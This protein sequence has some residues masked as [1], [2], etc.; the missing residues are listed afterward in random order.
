[1]QLLASNIAESDVNAQAELLRSRD[2]L[3]QALDRMGTLAM[4]AFARDQAIDDLER[5]L[6]VGPIPGSNLLQVSYTGSSPEKAKDVLQAITSSFVSSELALLRPTRQQLTQEL[7]DRR[8]SELTLARQIVASFNETNGIASA[9]ETNDV[10]PL[11]LVQSTEFDRLQESV[12][13]AQRK[14][15]F[16]VQ[17]RDQA[18]MEDALERDR[19]RNVAFASRPSASS[20]PVKPRPSSLFCFGVAQRDVPGL[21]YLRD[22]RAEKKHGLF[23]RRT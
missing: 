14:L 15:D 8:R 23:P 18:V 2:V 20:I 3:S 7:V 10:K 13:T 12:A 4:T 21:R 6:Q 17:Q 11:T 16:A 5:N 9:V 19:I 1:M 22:R